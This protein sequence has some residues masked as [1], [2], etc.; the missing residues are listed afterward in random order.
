MVKAASTSD[1]GTKIVKL[2]DDQGKTWGEISEAVGLPTG[3]C[4]FEYEKATVKPSTRITGKTDAELN[5]AIAKARNEGMSWGRIAARSGKSEGFC[6]SAFKEVTGE[7][8]RGHRIGKGGRFPDGDAPAK[9]KGAVKAG[10]AAKKATGAVKKAAKKAPASK[11][12]A[13]K[14][15]PIKKAVAKKAV[16]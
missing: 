14:K 7:E 6:K 3:K 8:A 13:A 10:G 2:K 5:K 16:A 4:M 1:V 9:A 12:A 15:T 11:K